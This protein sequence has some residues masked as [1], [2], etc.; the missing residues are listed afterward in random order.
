VAVACKNSLPQTLPTYPLAS[1]LTLGSHAIH[2]AAAASLPP[3]P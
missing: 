3:T 2:S 1:G